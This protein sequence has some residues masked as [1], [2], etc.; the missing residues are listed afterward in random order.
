MFV[1]HHIGAGPAP[2]DD[3]WYLPAGSASN[4]SGVRV[5]A[6]AAMRLS[7]VFKCVRA[8]AETVGMLPLPV[9][10][11]LTRG[12]E[13]RPDHPLAA[14]LQSAPNPWQTAMQWREMMQGHAALRG[15]AY[16]EI[17]YGGAGLAEMLLPLHPDFVTVEVLPSGMPRYRYAPP[18]KPART[19]VF[20]QVF[21][22]MG[23]ST[24]GYVGLSPI[25]AERESIGSAIATRDYGSRYFSND[26][27]APGWIEFEGKF[28]DE[29]AKRSWRASFRENYSGKNA[30]STFVLEKG[31]KYHELGI[32]N[33]DAQFLELRKY[34]DVDIAGLWR[35]PPHKIGILDRATWA[36]IEH[37]NLEW[38]TDCIL[39]WC[40]R[41]EQALQRDLGFGEDYFP[42]FLL[43]M[44]LRGDTKSRYEAYGKG[45]QDGWLLRNEAREL[46]NLNPIE[47]LD[48]PLEPMNMAPAGSR[49]ADQ[50]RGES[51]ASG[52]KVQRGGP[53]VGQPGVQQPDARAMLIMQAAA[54][55][56]ARKEVAALAKAVR[57]A[58]VPQAIEAALVGESHVKFVAEV[59]AVDAGTALVCCQVAAER[60]LQRHVA[61]ELAATLQED[62]MTVRATDLQ[63]LD[64]AAEAPVTAREMLGLVK[65][66]AQRTVELNVAQPAVNLT[67]PER[68]VSV[69]LG[70]VSVDVHQP[71]GSVMKEVLRRDPDTGLIQQTIERHL[72]S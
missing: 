12:K 68:A 40:V 8:I 50:A 33:T 2:Q 7:T 41:W 34:Q 20:G 11:R 72:D 65:A 32:K 28:Q 58:D 64:M 39:P 6:D 48:V 15:N 71:R 14:L 55:R 19:L 21:H 13:R 27:K 54:E 24:D 31:M 67:V 9:Y 26:A 25:E 63:R 36:N 16:S 47:G 44:L 17:V 45:I 1:S 57:A 10:K 70:G 22:L 43:A 62:W 49:G 29:Q 46:E 60:V 5:S 37:Q 3:F 52:G 42:E 51:T 53:G 4:A 23:F 69:E 66:V 38:V 56:V 59:M 35:V 30:G 18:N 61:G